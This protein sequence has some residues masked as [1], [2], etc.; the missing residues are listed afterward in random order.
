MNAMEDIIE[1]IKECEKLHHAEGKSTQ[2]KK[3]EKAVPAA[4]ET[5]L[6]ALEAFSES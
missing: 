1:K 2:T 3:N 4:S 5:R 6:Q